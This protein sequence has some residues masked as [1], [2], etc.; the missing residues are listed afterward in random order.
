[1]FRAFLLLALQSALA[2][3]SEQWQP[4]SVGLMMQRSYDPTCP[5]THDHLMK[6]SLRQSR[7]DYKQ[8]VGSIQ[9][10]DAGGIL[11]PDE[12]ENG[13]SQQQHVIMG[14]RNG[15]HHHNKREDES[16][17]SI[18]TWYT[19]SDLLDRE[20]KRLVEPEEVM[21][22]LSYSFMYIGRKVGT[23]R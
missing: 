18:I 10:M 22:F 20:L 17:Q 13:Q 16:F 1:M 3:S 7:R 11:L 14:D 2:L 8:T 4:I 21:M 9:R 15:T 6:Q 19:G 12:I 5:S 23:N